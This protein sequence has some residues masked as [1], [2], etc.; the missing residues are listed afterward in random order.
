MQVTPPAVPIEQEDHG[1]IAAGY[2][3]AEGRH[4]PAAMHRRDRAS[5]TQSAQRGNVAPPFD[6]HGN[7]IVEQPQLTEQAA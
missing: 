5:Q 1:G 4:R 2:P 6:D 7:F 3:L